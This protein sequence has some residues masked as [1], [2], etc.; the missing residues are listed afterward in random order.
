MRLFHRSRFATSPLEIEHSPHM[1][2]QRGGYP[3]KKLKPNLVAAELDRLEAPRKGKQPPIPMKGSMKECNARELVWVATKSFTGWRCRA[4]G[5]ARPYRR[6]ID[7]DSSSK[8]DARIAFDLHKC[9]ENPLH[10]RVIEQTRGA[11]G[12][13]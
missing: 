11:E 6:L 2:T 7:P 8:V 9:E 5:W 12:I 3:I 13:G 1:H 10:R 4:C